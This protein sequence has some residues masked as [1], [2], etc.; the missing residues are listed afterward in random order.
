LDWVVE[1]TPPVPVVERLC[2]ETVILAAYAVLQARARNMVV[3]IIFF[4]DIL[5]SGLRKSNIF[6]SDHLWQFKLA[7]FLS[8]N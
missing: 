4:M 3:A 5:L 7:R 1:C 8:G 2:F 6:M